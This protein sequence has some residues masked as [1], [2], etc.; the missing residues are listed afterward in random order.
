VDDLRWLDL[1]I[2]VRALTY[3]RDRE[4]LAA[5]DPVVLARSG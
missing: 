3:R 4:L 1:D 5:L 2:A